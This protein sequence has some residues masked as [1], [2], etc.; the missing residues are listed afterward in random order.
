MLEGLWFGQNV[1]VSRLIHLFNVVNV[2]PPL[3]RFFL[4][5]SVRGRKLTSI[6]RRQETITN[7]P[8]MHLQ[9]RDW[10]LL[11][12]PLNA[13]QH[14]TDPALEGDRYRLPEQIPP[15]MSTDVMVHK[16]PFLSELPSHILFRFW[17]HYFS[18]HPSDL[19]DLFL[20]V[21]GA[22]ISCFIYSC[23]KIVSW[24]FFLVSLLNFALLATFCLVPRA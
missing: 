10:D 23:L 17:W 5:R 6:N 3:E 18:L 19:L 15:P 16:N 11:L 4:E 13:F 20:A 12:D 1:A 2:D 7:D 24:T 21:V 9:C 8:C 14:F 22:Q